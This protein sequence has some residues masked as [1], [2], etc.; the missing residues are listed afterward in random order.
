MTHGIGLR[1][2]SL[3]LS[4]AILILSAFTPAKTVCSS[5]YRAVTILHTNDTHGHLLPFSYP[6]SLNNSEERVKIPIS[7]NIGGIARR[8]TLVHRIE[9]EVGGEV[10][11]LD[12]GDVM[13][14]TAFSIEYM[15]EADFAA[16]SAAKYDAFTPGNHEFS[17]SLDQFW[18][19]VK[20]ATFPILAANVI[21]KKSK[22]LVLPDHKIFD[23]HGVKI[24]VFG[25]T[26]PNEYRAAKDGLGFLDPYEVATELAPRL[27][28]QADVVIA[29]THLGL[30]NDIRLA[31]EVPA[32]DVIVGGHSHSRLETPLVIKHPGMRSAF[33]LGGTIIVQDHQW[34]GELGRL[35]LRLRRNNGPFT[36]MSYT[37]RLI[38]VTSDIPEDSA[39]ARIVARYYAPI[40]AKYEQIVGE[41]SDTFWN[42]NKL[43]NSMLNLVCDAMLEATGA[44]L[45]IYNEGGVRGNLAKGVIRYWNIAEAFPFKNKLVVIRVS[46]KELKRVLETERPGVSGARYRIRSGKLTYAMLD[47]KVIDEGKTYVVAT[48][49]FL[50]DRIFRDVS[51]SRTVSD[52]Y[53]QAIVSYIKTR[54]TITPVLDGRRII[55]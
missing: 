41:A 44:E 21:D 32:I 33:S 7:D 49:D 42:D 52:D 39:T 45:A 40:S 34:G 29:L 25:L 23:I 20:T 14:G 46:G 36:L 37:G 28:K 26:L 6:E 47:G 11:L 1:R 2:Y 50:A 18:K 10:L 54:K 16:M 53:R 43:E 5:E 19:N 15:G 24:A 12:A 48:V 8:A 17:T 31:E 13:D 51:D 35:D 30:E 38:P 55:D 4:I 27:K 3:C 9:N 22:K